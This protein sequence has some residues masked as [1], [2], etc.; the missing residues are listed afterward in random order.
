MK[1]NPASPAARAAARTRSDRSSTPPSG[2]ERALRPFGY[3][4]IA[5]VWTLLAAVT[6]SLPAALTVGLASSNADFTTRGFFAGSDIAVTVL[7]LAFSVVVLVPLLGY[8]FVALPLAT[9]PLAVLSWT[10]VLRSLS[11]AY[12]NERL[13]STGW[14]RNAIGPVTL[15]P[16]AMSLL[17]VRVTPWAAFWVRLMFLGWRPNRGV[18][19]AGIPYGLASFLLAGWLLWPVGPVAA[20]IWTIVTLALVALTVLLVV[21]ALRGQVSRQRAPRAAAGS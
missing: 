20:V 13:S 18:L 15:L 3:L 12:A 2:A 11:P 1:P 8:A 5:I 19:L 4:L 14:S 6:L 10:Y 7:F 16:T 9:V 21:R 17:P